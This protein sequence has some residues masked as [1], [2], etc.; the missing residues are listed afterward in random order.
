MIE[1]LHMKASMAPLF[2]DPMSPNMIEKAFTQ[3]EYAINITDETGT[4][5]KVNQA[6]LN[7]YKFGNESEV[8]GKRQNMIR[9]PLTPANVYKTMWATITSGQTWRGEIS[10]KAKDGSEVFIH[11][12]ITPIRDG[13]KIVGYMGF[14]LD[15]G[16]QV[17]LERQLFHANKLV[18]LGTLG[19][20]LAHELNNPLA[21]ILL[22]AEF[23]RDVLSEPGAKIDS[24]SAQSA[25]NSVIKGAERMKK[26]V[27]HLLIYSRRE[28]NIGHSTVTLSNL[29]KDSFLFLEKQLKNRGIEIDLDVDEKLFVVGNKT[30]LESV[31]HNLLSN[32]R[33]AFE[34]A[35]IKTKK[36]FI[37]AEMCSDGFVCLHYRDNAGGIP[38]EILNRIYEPFFTTKRETEGTGLGLSITRKI[39]MEHGGR[40]ECESELEETRFRIWLPCFHHIDSKLNPTEKMQVKHLPQNGIKKGPG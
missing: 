1:Y 24:A 39:I 4:L 29:I 23:L 7:L 35:S 36:I 30:Q 11:L 17:L 18:I 15:R 28:T 14:S 37:Q 3:A 40:I 34:T 8:I 16:Q 20:S 21:S 25:A 38:P 13:D 9:S 12:T 27:E 31:V 19:A 10:N 32:S 2:L 26:V 22:D 6:Y 33:D 5:L